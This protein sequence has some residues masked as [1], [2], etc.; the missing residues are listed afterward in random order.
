MLKTRIIPCLL[1]KDG[2][3]TKTIRFGLENPNET[4]R[5]IGNYIAAVKVFNARDV[6]ELVFLD[7][8]ATADGRDPLYP[9]IADVARECFMPLAVGGGVRTLEHIERLLNVGADKVVLNT[10]AIEHSE[11]ITQA[12]NRYGAQLVV[13]SIDVR[14]KNGNYGVYSRNGS[15]P[16]GMN[17]VEWATRGEK[18]GA[19]EI[20]LTSIDHDG[21]MDGYDVNLTELVAKSVRIPVIA[22]GGAGQLQHFVD[23]VKWGKADAV[24]AASIFQYTQY[25]P[26]DIKAHLAEHGVPVRLQR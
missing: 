26:N 7:I 1:L 10:A 25:T 8:S 20:F 24:A 5:N 18:L 16:T 3:L 17:P 4:I 13:L 11:L 14:K 22:S 23:V 15:K 19:G 21:V 12:A 2:K 6:D 9:V